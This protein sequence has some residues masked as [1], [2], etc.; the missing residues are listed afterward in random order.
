[1]N[2]KL[3]E[4][5]NKRLEKLVEQRLKETKFEVKSQIANEECL[6]EEFL[7]DLMNNSV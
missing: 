5:W 1:M 2:Q 6:I 4:Y 7:F 3:I